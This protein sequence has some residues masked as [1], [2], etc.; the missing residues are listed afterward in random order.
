M[1]LSLI[2]VHY[3]SEFKAAFEAAL[4]TLSSRERN[5]LRLHILD[6]LNIEQI[7]T[8]YKAHRATVARW[9]AASRKKIDEGTRRALADKLKLGEGARE[10][11]GP[12]P[13]PARRER[14]PPPRRSP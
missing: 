8:L 11:D 6:G 4:A 7:G 3:R 12:R 10:L 2:K 1:E 13:E 5:V 9:I 14:E